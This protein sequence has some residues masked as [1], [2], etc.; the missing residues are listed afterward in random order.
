MSLHI[1]FLLVAGFALLSVVIGSAL[2][3]WVIAPTATGHGRLLIRFGMAVAAVSSLSAAMSSI[4][5]GATWRE[6][7]HWELAADAGFAVLAV[8]ILLSAIERA[9]DRGAPRNKP[10]H[11]DASRQSD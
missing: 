11:G 5:L 8:G 9:F 6:R 4:V 3:F 10:H 7:I 1:A 2:G